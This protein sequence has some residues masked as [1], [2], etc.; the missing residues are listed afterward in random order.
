MTAALYLNLSTAYLQTSDVSRARE[1]AAA[2]LKMFSEAKDRVGQAQAL[3]ASAIGAQ[4]A[5][6]AAEAKRLFTQAAETL[7]QAN[8]TGAAPDSGWR[9]A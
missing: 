9:C 1:M 2:A 8:G 5:G 4:R 7:K 3:H 6:D